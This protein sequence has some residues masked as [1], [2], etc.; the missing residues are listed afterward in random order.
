MCAISCWGSNATWLEPVAW[1]S[2]GKE[3]KSESHVALEGSDVALGV[4][5]D[6]AGTASLDFVQKRGQKRE[7]RRI[8]ESDV[9]LGVQ[10]DVA[11]TASLDFVQKRGEKREPR[12]IVGELCRVVGANATWLG[13]QA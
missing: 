10:R 12:R 7:P 3:V 1:F 4:Q 2:D 13:Q 6:V 5:R 9:V 8:G 11:G